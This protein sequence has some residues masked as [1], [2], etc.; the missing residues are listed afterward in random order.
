[1][2]GTFIFWMYPYGKFPASITA[3]GQAFYVVKGAMQ[4]RWVAENDTCCGHQ[5][6][7]WDGKTQH[8][9]MLRLMFQFD[10]D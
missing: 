7:T 1:M 4:T 2:C 8:D 5:L 9:F 6:S 3:G 10:I